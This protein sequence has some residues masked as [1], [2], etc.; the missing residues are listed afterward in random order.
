V[1]AL[2]DRDENKPVAGKEFV[3]KSF[4]EYHLYTLS[5]PSTVRDREAKQLNLLHRTGVTAARRYVY[6]PAQGQQVAVEL[7]ARNEKENG[8]GLPLPKGRVTLEQR[9]Q[10]GESAF[11]GSTE[12]DHTAVKEEL[13]LRYGS[14]FDVAGDFKETAPHQYEMRIRNHKTHEI[15]VRAVAHM[16]VGWRISFSSQAFQQHDVET[17]YFDFPLK[18]NAEQV[19]AY[20]LGNP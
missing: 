14:A 8:L 11:L 9:D 5:A 15:Q 6:H 13:T 17:A 4:F 3:E 19:I 12:I 16:A 1:D 7:V 20:T 18:P 10:D 2:G